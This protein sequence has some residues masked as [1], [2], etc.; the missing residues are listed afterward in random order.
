MGM[1]PRGA[2]LT[3]ALCPAALRQ[4]P[5]LRRVPDQRAVGGHRCPL[6]RQVGA[7]WPWGGGGGRGC[8]GCPWGS[9]SA[10]P[11]TTDAVV[12]GEYD[13]ET[14]SGDVQRLS[15]AKVFRNPSY[16]SLTVRNDITLIKLATPAQLNARVSPVC[17]PQATDDFPGGLTC[18]TTGWGLT[19]ASGTAAPSPSP[20]PSPCRPRGPCGC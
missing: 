18:V 13:Q 16:S 15:I 2:G 8:A 20:L 5:L 10:L 3:A 1:G 17:L 6:R 14:E 12:L 9:A 11:R 7:G 19:D 4:L